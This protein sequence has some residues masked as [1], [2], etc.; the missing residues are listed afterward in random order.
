MATHVEAGRQ[1]TYRAARM[2]D[3]GKRCDLEAGMAKAFCAEMAEH[4]TSE[5]MQISGGYGYSPEF[6]AQRFRRHALGLR[7]FVATSERQYGMNAKRQ[8]EGSCSLSM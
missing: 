1:L 6:P 7:I 5:G 2:K 3:T 4:V 8:L